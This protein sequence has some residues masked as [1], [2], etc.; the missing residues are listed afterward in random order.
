MVLRGRMQRQGAGNRACRAAVLR[1]GLQTRTHKA[2]SAVPRAAAVRHRD[3]ATRTLPIRGRTRREGGGIMT[4][5]SRPARLR[6]RLTAI[7]F[8]LAVVLLAAPAQAAATWTKVSSP[9]RGTVASVLQ[10]V[11]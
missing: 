11:A 3:S 6:P 2:G 7:L 8:V 9:N 1:T 4:S 5:R 10:D